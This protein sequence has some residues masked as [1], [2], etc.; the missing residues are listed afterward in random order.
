MSE[1]ENVGRKSVMKIVAGLAIFFAILLPDQIPS[2]V[3]GA[4]PL[5]GVGQR[6]LAA[7]ALI[8]FWWLTGPIELAATSV[9]PIVLFPLMGIMSANKVSKTYLNDNIH[10][11]MGG[12]IIALGIEKWKLHRR[13][14]LWV[15]SVFGTGPRRILLGIMSAAA[16]LSMWISNTATTLLMLPIA[17]A[18]VDA[19]ESRCRKTELETGVRE[20]IARFSTAML[21]GIAYGSSVGGVGT[22]IGTPPNMIFVGMSAKQF[23]DAPP[24]SFSAWMMVF[25]PFTIVMTIFIWWLLAPKDM[26]TNAIHGLGR[27]IIRAE[28]ERLGPMGTAEKRMLVVFACTAALWMSR[29]S[30]DLGEFHL[31]GWSDGLQVLAHRIGWTEFTTSMVSD[32]TVAIGMS[33]LMFFLP[34]GQHE[35]G[36]SRLMDWKTATKL[37]WGVLILIG[38]GFA[39]AEAFETSGASSWVGSQ[40]LIVSGWQPI[41]IVAGVCFVMT[42]LTEI[43]SN[44]ATTSVMLPILA[45]SSET[46]GVHP[47]LLMLPATISASCAFM[48]PVATPPNAIVFASGRLQITDMVRYGIII[49]LVG[50][51]I[52]TAVIFLLAVPILGF[53]PTSP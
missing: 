4:P 20:A 10:L 44:V 18:L 5:D 39:I 49:N 1:D 9:L 25:V 19:F 53:N 36:E 11:Y 48:L 33:A 50:V 13:L 40:F 47:W 21:L 26:G 30:V 29:A 12:F 45:A 31:P 34:S 46:L 22:L 3:E 15:L 2:M 8:A 6:T 14:A 42:F 24:I 23:P 43:T 41:A 38:G 32:A 37:P 27:D 51:V 35:E 28:L 16:F 17:M 7:S 52:V